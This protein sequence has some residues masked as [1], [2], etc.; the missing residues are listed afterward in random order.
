MARAAGI[1][2]SQLFRWRQELCGPRRAVPGFSAVSVVPE[3]AAAATLPSA[4]E[5]EFE[6]GTRM[7]ITGPIEASVVR[8]VIAALA[9]TERR[10]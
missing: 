5:V 6:T 3:A 9:K 2:V 1:H 7:R 8:A 4:I 10:R